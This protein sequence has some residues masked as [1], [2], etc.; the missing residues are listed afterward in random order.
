MK[1]E[2]LGIYIVINLKTSYNLLF[3][4][5]NIFVYFIKIYFYTLFIEINF[6]QTSF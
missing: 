3:T 4:L 5:F 1:Y 2:I 6:K